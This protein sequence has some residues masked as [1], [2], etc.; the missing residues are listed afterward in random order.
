MRQEPIIGIKFKDKKMY[1]N[2]ILM[3]KTIAKSS[4]SIKFR[5]TENKFIFYSEN[6]T[7][8]EI[9]YVINHKNNPSIEFHNFCRIA[10]YLDNFFAENLEEFL[11]LEENLKMEIDQNKLKLNLVSEMTTFSYVFYYDKEGFSDFRNPEENYHFKLDYS[12]LEKLKKSNDKYSTN[13]IFFNKDKFKFVPESNNSMGYHV[14]DNKNF[15]IDVNGPSFENLVRSFSDRFK[16]KNIPPEQ[17]CVC[18]SVNQDFLDIFCV[19]PTFVKSS[20]QGKKEKNLDTMSYAK[21]NQAEKLIFEEKIFFKITD[22][23]INRDENVKFVS[24]AKVKMSAIRKNNQKILEEFH[25]ETEIEMS[26]SNSKEIFKE[27]DDDFK[28]I[29]EQLK[30]ETQT[31]LN[32]SSF[33]ILGSSQNQ[34]INM[35]SLMV[36]DMQR[37]KNQVEKRF[38]NNMNNH[39][40]NRNIN[41]SILLEVNIEE[42][43]AEESHNF[44]PNFYAFRDKNQQNNNID[45]SLNY[46]KLSESRLT[47]NNLGY[48]TTNENRFMA[49][50][51]DMNL[52]FETSDESYRS[53]NQEEDASYINK[54]SNNPN[55]NINNFS[56]R[57]GIYNITT[58]STNINNNLISKPKSIQPSNNNNFLNHNQMFVANPQHNNMKFSS[59]NEV[60]NK[61]IINVNEGSK[62][63]MDDLANKIGLSKPKTMINNQILPIQNFPNQI[64]QN[65][66]MINQNIRN[67]L[68]NN[69]LK[70]LQNTL[71]LNDYS[72]GATGSIGNVNTKSPFCTSLS[73][74][75]PARKSNENEILSSSGNVLKDILRP[76][77]VSAN[78][79]NQQN[80]NI[81]QPFEANLNKNQEKINNNPFTGLPFGPEI[82]NMNRQN[83][84]FKTIQKNTND[85][86]SNIKVEYDAIDIINR[87]KQE[88]DEE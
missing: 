1:G 3:M 49:K 8:H 37:T 52:H 83:D 10:I 69:N 53:F 66:P 42:E 2:I 62:K 47:E 64:K 24:P 35:N 81:V 56:S 72:K 32:V 12:H 76:N 85:K 59:N 86:K 88:E 31:N 84:N 60:G 9:R 67:N 58:K 77:V 40:V 71:I 74:I 38:I 5:I 30:D 51:P 80:N 36:E 78:N 17:A 19:A 25:F 15:G 34:N 68:D 61:N 63:F 46:I 4:N 39:L 82:L 28:K 55:N 54:M 48:N 29:K 11:S 50:K 73:K 14:E 33:Y 65:Y 21:S 87:I 27:N 26:M 44:D 70:Q 45:E 6:N 75:D 7:Q 79:R 18:F 13:N 43:Q 22:L 57:G 20:K 41:N 23:Q 16:N